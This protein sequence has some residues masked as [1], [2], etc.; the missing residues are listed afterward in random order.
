MSRIIF[1]MYKKKGAG[2]PF[3]KSINSYGRYFRLISSAAVIEDGNPIK[4][5]SNEIISSILCVGI[6]T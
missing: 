6:S 5:V 1:D 2:A 4:L 3:I